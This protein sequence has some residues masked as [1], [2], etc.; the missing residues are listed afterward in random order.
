MRANKLA[1]STLQTQLVARYGPEGGAAALA[2][3]ALR[4]PM[5]RPAGATA[6]ATSAAE[7]AAVAA[8]PETGLLDA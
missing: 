4:R 8:L 3:L 6:T 1:V 5:R 2:A 7:C